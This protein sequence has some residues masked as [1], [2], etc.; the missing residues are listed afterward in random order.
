MHQIDVNLHLPSSAMATP[1]RS[2]RPRNWAAWRQELWGFLGAFGCGVVGYLYPDFR[3]QGSRNETGIGDICVLF[4]NE[5]HPCSFRI[6]GPSW[7]MT[8]WAPAISG[9]EKKKNRGEEIRQAAAVGAGGCGLV[10]A[11]ALACR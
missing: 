8:R 3:G 9:R 6:L 11:R 7:R 2:V 1:A 10:H 5:V 4:S